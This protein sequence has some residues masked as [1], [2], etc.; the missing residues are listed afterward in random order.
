MPI[1]YSIDTEA[2]IVLTKASGRLSDEDI[3]GHKKSLIEDPRFEPGMREISDVRDVTELAVTPT[4]IRTFVSFDRAS[5]TD[6][7]G[8]R[9]A[10]VASEDFVFGTARMYQMTGS[11]DDSV[12]VFRC[13]DEARAWLGVET[14]SRSS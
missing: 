1:S 2:G 7:S 13:L 9:L 11:E 10:I 6:R 4:G 3:L 8:H 14:P 5:A 12:G